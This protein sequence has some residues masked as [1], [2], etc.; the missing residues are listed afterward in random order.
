MR[1]KFSQSV[2]TRLVI[3]LVLSGVLLSLGLGILEWRR[4]VPVL[5]MRLTQR[6]SLTTRNIQSL[7]RGVIDVQKDEDIE[8]ALRVVTGESYVLGVSVVRHELRE[9]RIG[10]W[11]ITD[12]ATENWLLPEHGLNYQSDVDWQLLTVVRAPFLH[13]GKTVNL[14]LLIDGSAAWDTAKHE[15]WSQLQT[16]WLFLS[17]VVLVG[18]LLLR[19]WFT[20]PLSDI[21]QLVGAGAGPGS[22]YEQSQ[23]MTG[24]FSLLAETLGG[25]LSKLE[26]TSERLRHRENAFE[27]LYQF[28]PVAMVS[29]QPDGKIVEANRKAA[30]LLSVSREHDLVGHTLFEFV[31]K[32]DRNLIKQTMDRL[33]LDNSAK[34]ELRLKSRSSEIDVLLEGC[35]VR[36]EDGS[37]LRIRVSLQDVSQSRLLQNQLVEKSSLL[38][39]VVE[40]MSDAIMLVDENGRVAAHNQK[41]VAL[42]HGRVESFVGEMY[43]A[44]RFWDGLS[45]E[46]HEAFSQQLRQIEAE[47][48]RPVHHRVVTRCGTFLFQGVPVRDTEEQSVGRLWVVQE[49]TAQDQTERLMQQQANQLHVLKR[50]GYELRDIRSVD[51]LVMRTS[52]LLYEMFGVECVGMALRSSKRGSRSYQTLHRG[53]RASLYQVDRDVIQAVECHLMSQVLSNADVT[54]WP[55]LPRGEKWVAPFDQAGFTSVAA[56]ALR[57]SSDGQ[58]V[59]WIARCGGE[60]IERQHVHLLEAI[61][62]LISARVEYAQQL[63]CLRDLELADPVTDLSNRQCFEMRLQQLSNKPGHPWSV[64][65]VSIDHFK[66]LNDNLGHDGGDALLRRVGTLL[67]SRVRRVCEVVRLGGKQFAVIC[68]DIDADD[69]R[70]IAERIRHAI[71]LQEITDPSGQ[72]WTLS[73]SIGVASSPGDGSYWQMISEISAARAE[74]ARRAGRNCVVDTGMSVHKH[75]G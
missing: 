5:Q 48:E 53:N 56:G 52:K 20:S 3:C 10:D 40:H 58:G 16:Q 51:D 4:T 75:A 30:A 34:C 49:V 42:L 21:S 14:R 66:Q 12:A 26:S 8:D 7:L 45:I 36:D 33:D 64:V 57:G 71:S 38:N 31:A 9:L 60:H 47:H 28:A 70:N 43:D 37:L 54:F 18:L 50:L 68:P 73:A 59:L 25:M 55:D 44:E 69:A 65:T 35:S 29:L 2:M 74:A 27:S 39:L 1:V 24:E 11:E 22:F 23:Q 63:E 67:R 13:N 72:T 32:R 19:R 6:V 17:V 46:D 62:P 41:L 61:V 15:M